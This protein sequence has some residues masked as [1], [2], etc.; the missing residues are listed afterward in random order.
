[1]TNVL[2]VDYNNTLIRSISVNKHLWGPNGEFTGGIYGVFSQLMLS[3]RTFKPSHLLVCTDSKPYLREKLYPGFKGD[4]KHYKDDGFDFYKAL[5]Q[6]TE[7]LTELFELMRIPVWEI[8]GLEADDLIAFAVQ[9]LKYDNC[10]IKS[11]DTDLNQLLKYSGVI[12]NKKGKFSTRLDEYRLEEFKTEFP[13]L[14]PVD[15]VEYTAMVG[16]HNGV[17]G[18]KGIGPATATKYLNNEEL[19]EEFKLK[20]LDALNQKWDLI[21]LPFPFYDKP[22]RVPTPRA[23][24]GDYRRIVG[25][26]ESLGIT[27]TNKMRE[28]LEEFN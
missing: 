23:P 19:Y 21:K 2:L 22:M 8:P 12:I 10:V 6:S 28:A 11:N 1:M 24:S 3:F 5:Y 20:H 4:R 15:W 17:P 26:L 27:F 14:T 25:L 18:I 9:T 13:K 7:L 16:T